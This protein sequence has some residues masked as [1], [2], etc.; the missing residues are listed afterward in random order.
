M[1]LSTDSNRRSIQPSII[2]ANI[3]SRQIARKSMGDEEF[4][5]KIFKSLCNCMFMIGRFKSDVKSDAN[6]EG[7]PG[8]YDNLNLTTDEG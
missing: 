7:V 3:Q 6:A 2:V 8:M 4:K 1:Q 5:P